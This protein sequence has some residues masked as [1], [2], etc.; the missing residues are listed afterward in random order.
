MVHLGALIRLDKSRPKFIVIFDNKFS[1]GDIV[2]RPK[3]ENESSCGGVDIMVF[4]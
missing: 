3:K 2:E 4:W 1:S